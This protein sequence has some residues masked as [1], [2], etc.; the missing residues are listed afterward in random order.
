LFQQ[1]MKWFR[2]NGHFRFWEFFNQPI[3]E[4]WSKAFALP[5]APTLQVIIAQIFQIPISQFLYKSKNG[6]DASIVCTSRR[7]P[8]QDPQAYNT[9]FFLTTID[10]GPK[11]N[12]MC[13]L[14]NTK[15]EQSSVI[16][17][18]KSGSMLIWS[19]A[20]LTQRIIS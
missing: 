16:P 19:Q 10:Y 1:S 13:H 8:E 7:S 12:F 3:I 2:C 11:K 18:K 6:I 5:T 4:V 14:G 17:F 15:I 20:A 9:F